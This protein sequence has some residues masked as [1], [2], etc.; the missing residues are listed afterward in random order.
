MQNKNLGVLVTSPRPKDYIL[1]GA[2]TIT[3]TR[4]VKDWSIYLPDFELQYDKVTDFLDCVSMSAGHSIEMQL[5]YLMS[6][7]QL[8]DEALNFFHNNNYIVN[9]VFHISKRFNAKMNGTDKT[10]GQYL[11]V[12][13][14]HFRSDGFIPDSLWPVTDNMTWDEFYAP[15]PQNLIDLGKKALW[16]ISIQYQWTDQSNIPN[17]LIA[18]PVQIASEICAGWD[19]GKVVQKCSGQPL[20][21]ST[22]I[23]GR[24]GSN[25]YLDLD[26]Y[27]PFE[28][29]LS[30]NYELPANMQYFITM[31]PVALRKGMF[32]ANVTL[33]QEDLNKIGN[34]KLSEDGSFGQI[35][36]NAVVDFQKNHGL[37]ADGIAGPLTLGKIKDIIETPSGT[38]IKDIITR[39]CNENG[40]EPELALSVASCEGGLMNPNITRVNTDFHHSTD[41][42]IFQYNSYWLSYIP[43]SVAFDVALAT[44][45]F[46]DLVKQG[47]LVQ[48][49]HLSQHCWAPNL[50]TPV[51]QKYGV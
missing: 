44:K 21:H 30:A 5:N 23:Y 13:G 11:N 37:G 2:S 20:Q 26:H 46:C 28:Q 50:S 24:D 8:S 14:D 4:A 39:V 1:G 18:T 15:V 36:Q 51:R 32:G 3:I 10:Q 22:V 43:D 29:V 19:S 40:V 7:H 48:L 9:G 45:E 49:W 41:R 16:Y 47:V 17:A 33:M 42:G 27:A 6:Q 35:T 12:A 31:K 25:N 34:Y 38:S